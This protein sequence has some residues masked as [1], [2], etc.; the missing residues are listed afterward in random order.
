MTGRGEF[1][2]SARSLI[3]AFQKTLAA[4]PAAVPQML[5]ACEFDLAPQ[6]EIVVAG[7]RPE[8]LV[9]L[10]WEKFDPNRVVLY[11]DAETAQYQPGIAAMRA[12]DGEAA[13]YIC[14][15]F[16]CRAPA[17]SEEELRGL[18]E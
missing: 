3:A 11:A 16:T 2:E 8:P 4:Q 7:P 1:E 9:R 10:L 15:N 18:L 13:V 5:A 17:T 12:L 14:E 6:R